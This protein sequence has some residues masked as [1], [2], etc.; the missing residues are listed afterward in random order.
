MGDGEDPGVVIRFGD[1]AKLKQGSHRYP[2][3]PW[4]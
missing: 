1:I 4:K 3:F 2:L